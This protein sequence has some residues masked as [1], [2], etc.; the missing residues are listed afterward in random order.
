[1][2]VKEMAVWKKE[3]R[4]RDAIPHFPVRKLTFSG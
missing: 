2:V 3:M 1:M 4:N